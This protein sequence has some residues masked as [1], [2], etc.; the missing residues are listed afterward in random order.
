[1]VKIHYYFYFY[2]FV[3]VFCVGKAFAGRG[4]MGEWYCARCARL[5]I[6]PAFYDGKEYGGFFKS[7]LLRA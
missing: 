6:M 7:L 1:M 4:F 2:G 5:G 3:K